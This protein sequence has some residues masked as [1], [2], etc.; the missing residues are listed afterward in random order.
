MSY[1]RTSR[2]DTRGQSTA[3]QIQYFLESTAAAGASYVGLPKVDVPAGMG[4]IIVSIAEKYADLGYPI[5][6]DLASPQIKHE[7]ASAQSRIAVDKKNYCGYGA[8]NDDPYGKAH[9]FDSVYAGVDMQ[10]RHLIGYVYGSTPYNSTRFYRLVQLNYAGKAQEL[11]QLEQ[12]W[13]WSDPEDYEATPLNQRYGAKIAEGANYLLSLI[14]KE[15]PLK[16]PTNRMVNM[17]RERG[18]EVHDVRGHLPVNRNHPY[19][20]IPHSAV[21]YYIQHWTGDSFSRDTIEKITGTDY[22]TNI[23]TPNMTVEDEIDMLEWYANY[24]ISKDGGTWGGIAYGTLVFPSGRIYVAWDIGT[25]T[26][27]AYTANNKSYAL[28]CPNANA[29]QPTPQQLFAL[30]NVWDVLCFHTPEIPAGHPELFGHGEATFL[31][32]RNVTSC[33]GTFLS[34]VRNYRANPQIIGQPPPPAPPPVSPNLINGF[35]VVE[36]I[37]DEYTMLGEEAPSIIGVPVS[38]MFEAV[39]DGT[40]RLVQIFD[41]GSLAI[42]AEGTPHGAPVNTPWH[43]R[44]LFPT[45][46]A[47]ALAQ[48]KALGLVAGWVE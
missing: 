33:P 22:G 18:F 14:P 31:D 28:C 36:E 45:E 43:V 47:Q 38:G 26:Y 42:Y 12:K 19:G 27:H 48:G 2:L 8:E 21:S 10:F 4:L 7:S 39:I 29:A 13:A 35:W 25:F 41:R 6:H 11:W 40:A 46:R 9:D 23:I 1:S 44:Q 16:V 32:S 24:H 20:K 5:N 30:S 37:Y 34:A 3:E 17:L 15:D